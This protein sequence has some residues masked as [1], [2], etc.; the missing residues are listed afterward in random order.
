M[1]A[2][3]AIVFC[4]LAVAG[5]VAFAATNV[6]QP[7]SISRTGHPTGPRSKASS[8]APRARSRNHV[9]GAPIQHPI[10][11][12]RTTATLRPAKRKPTAPP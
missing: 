8:F 4:L 1:K 5:S 2:L 11:A 10:L 12:K 7:R 9:Y 3:A 6:V